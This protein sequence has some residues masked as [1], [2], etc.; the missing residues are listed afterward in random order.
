MLKK[1]ATKKMLLQKAGQDK[2]TRRVTIN[3]NNEE[4]QVRKHEF[5]QDL[6]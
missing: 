5:E 2:K 6:G 3:T 1:T 4:K